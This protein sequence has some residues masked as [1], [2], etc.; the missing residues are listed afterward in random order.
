MN[1]KR[2]DVAN[3]EYIKYLCEERNT[4]SYIPLADDEGLENRKWESIQNF[5]TRVST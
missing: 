1:R 5:M 3:R 2:D 4:T